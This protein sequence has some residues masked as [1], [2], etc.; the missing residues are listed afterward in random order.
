M[1]SLPIGRLF[2]IPVYLHFSFLIMF[3]IIALLNPKMIL[4][5]VIV[6]GVVVLHELAHALTARHYGIPTKDITLYPIGGM[7]SLAF[8][9]KD[10]KQ[11]LTIALAGPLSNGVFA[12]ASL[13]CL[14][15]VEENGIAFRL[16]SYF[17]VIN[18]FLGLFNLL[19]AF[20]M[21]GGRVLRAYLVKRKG[22]VGATKIAAQVGRY[23]AVGLGILG[24]V[25]ILSPMIVIIAVF[26]WLAGSAEETQVVKS[27]FI[28]QSQRRWK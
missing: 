20:P 10:P 14:F 2:G 1:K 28:A 12:L 13:W 6:F 26:I 24:L 15:L 8:M 27:H 4:M 22:Y 25:G 17:V 19:P 21:D 9:P 18:I 7:A 5:Y 3:G 16:I 11:E 23:A